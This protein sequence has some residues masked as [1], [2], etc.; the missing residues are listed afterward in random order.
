MQALNIV[1]LLSRA[2]QCFN[3]DA[4]SVIEPL[5]LYEIGI[6]VQKNKCFLG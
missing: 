5:L 1:T 4:L 3:K 6:S 2:R